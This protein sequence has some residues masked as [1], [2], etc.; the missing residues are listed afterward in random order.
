MLLRTLFSRAATAV[1][2]RRLAPRASDR[3]LVPMMALRSPGLVSHAALFS[4][5]P[6]PEGSFKN[7]DDGPDRV[8]LE[9]RTTLK[10]RKRFYKKA[11]Y[12]ESVEEPGMFEVTLD[13]RAVKAGAGE[14][15]RVPSVDM[16]MIIAAEWG[17]Q[18]EMLEPAAMPT[19][20][21]AATAQLMGEKRDSVIFSLLRFVETDT[22]CV[23]SAEDEDA[24]LIRSEKKHWDPIVQWFREQYGELHTTNGFVM[25]DQPEE[26]CLLYTSPSPRD[27][28]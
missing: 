2:S 27:R 4:D 12:R 7:T 22:V 8:S 21:M 18:G 15:L 25:P 23:R 14:N 28:G 10:G 13:G 9:P 6:V 19:M 17:A 24:N 20:S 5:I 26:T 1:V 3:H 11:G 16:A